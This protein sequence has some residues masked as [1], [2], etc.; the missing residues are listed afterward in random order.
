MKHSSKL[1]GEYGNYDKNIDDRYSVVL[2]GWLIVNGKM[3]IKIITITKS[4]YKVDS[5]LRTSHDLAH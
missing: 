3:I 4:Y 2:N 5:L 1:L